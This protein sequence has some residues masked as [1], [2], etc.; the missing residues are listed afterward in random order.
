MTWEEMNDNLQKDDYHSIWD[1][2]D[3]VLNG[4]FDLNELNIF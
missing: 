3:L 1:N 2:S 4:I